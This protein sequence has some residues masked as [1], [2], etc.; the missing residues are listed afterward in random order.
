MYRNLFYLV[1]ICAL[2][3]AGYFML[4]ADQ[5]IQAPV[6][7]ET[8]PA[9]DAPRTF[10]WRFTSFEGTEDGLPPRTDV[11]LITNGDTYN[12]GGYPGSCAELA[13][14][15]LLPGE[16]SGVLCW[17]AGAG[18]EIGVFTLEDGYVVRRGFQEEPTAETAGSRGNF[19][20]LVTLE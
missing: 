9:S 4:R 7:T 17:W 10:S 15:E 16:V 19:N 2:L 1:A 18:D 8:V 5:R 13:P 3:A 6:R 12:L 14:A 11:A 20:D